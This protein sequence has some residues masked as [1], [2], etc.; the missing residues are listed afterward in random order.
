MSHNSIYQPVTFTIVIYL[1]SISLVWSEVINNSSASTPSAS[2]IRRLN[3]FKQ[4]YKYLI[5]GNVK[6]RNENKKQVE[7][8]NDKIELMQKSA[9]STGIP[10]KNL[11]E[12]QELLTLYKSM[13]L[14]NVTILNSLDQGKTKTAKNCMVNLPEIEERIKMIT[15]RPIEREWLTFQELE[16]YYAKGYKCKLSD[17][18]IIPFK[19]SLWDTTPETTDIKGKA[20]DKIRKK[21]SA[22]HSPR[23]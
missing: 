2:T 4:S 6:D 13:Y 12:Y 10:V 20:T 16:E 21:S 7:F 3:E 23:P 1:F 9:K 5:E 19:A 17:Q 8:Y 11:K 22:T 18:T 15:G 14:L